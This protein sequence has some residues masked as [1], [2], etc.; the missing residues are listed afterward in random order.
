MNSSMNLSPKKKR[1][2]SKSSKPSSPPGK[3]KKKAH[4]PQL[5]FD[6]YDENDKS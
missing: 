1:T 4:V 2:N 6:C 5:L 3:R